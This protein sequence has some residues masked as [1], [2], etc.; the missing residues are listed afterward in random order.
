MPDLSPAFHV[1]VG[2][3]VH[4]DIDM[5]MAKLF[6]YDLQIK[7]L[8]VLHAG[9]QIMPQHM[10]GR[11]DAEAFSDLGI[12][13]REIRGTDILPVLIRKYQVR[14]LPVPRLQPRNSLQMAIVSQLLAK[15]LGDIDAAAALLSLGI[16]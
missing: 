9:G 3:D 14:M 4:R 15:R 5:R 13:R 12:I 1:E 6:L 2:V 7:F 8:T 16:G 10:E 11:P